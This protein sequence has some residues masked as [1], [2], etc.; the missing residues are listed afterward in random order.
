MRAACLYLSVGIRSPAILTPVAEVE[1]GISPHGEAVV[2]DGDGTSGPVGGHDKHL[3]I[4]L[5]LDG[6]TLELI[7]GG[8]F[9]REGF[10]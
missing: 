9:L 6:V 5:H 4:V 3:A 10:K 1:P 2:L 8:T 7:T